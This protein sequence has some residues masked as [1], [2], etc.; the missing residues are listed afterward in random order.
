MKSIFTVLLFSIVAATA[1][2]QWPV[3]NSAVVDQVGWLTQQDKA[4]IENLIYSYHQKGRAQVQVVIVNDLQGLPVESYSVKLVERWKLGDKKR[5]DG[6]LFLISSSDRKM[7]IEV[8]Q[9]LEGRLTDLQSKRILDDRVRPLFKSKNYAAGVAAGVVEIISAI[10]PEYAGQ[11]LAARP[12]SAPV[13]DEQP[14]YV[15]ILVVLFILINIFG[16]R[17]RSSGRSGGI[18]PFLG[19]FML[20]GGGRSSG[21][22]G[23]GWS[24]GGGGFSGGG[25]SSD[26]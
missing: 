11:A 3:M 12:M 24:G 19:G 14:S 6:V 4:E 23:G 25:A 15:W 21:G 13:S 2:I 18:L 20:G 10:D 22:G 16:R 8:G 26:W 1:D 7:R 17:R 5:D 9:G